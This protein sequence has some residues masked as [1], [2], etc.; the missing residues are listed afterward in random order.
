M[1]LPRDCLFANSG[2]RPLTASRQVRGRVWNTC[3]AWNEQSGSHSHRRFNSGFVP[4]LE[5]DAPLGG[6]RQSFGARAR[7]ELAEERLDV[8][9]HR[10]KRDAELAGDSL[11]RVALADRA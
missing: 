5:L 8:E 10:V 1:Q 7:A 3:F 11:V 9:L 6:L 4:E 2:R